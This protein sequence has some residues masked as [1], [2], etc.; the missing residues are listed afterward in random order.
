MLPVPVVQE[1]ILQRVTPLGVEKIHLYD[2]LGRVLAEAIVTPDPIPAW[3]NSA[4]DGYA[5]ALGDWQLTPEPVLTI[6]EELPAGKIPQKPLQPGFCSRV[7]TGALLPEGTEA[8]VMQEQAE[9]LGG[10]RVQL[11][12]YPRSGQFMR[13]RGEFRSSGETLITQG[14]AI[15]PAE[16][17]ILASLNKLQV[18]VYRQP[19]VA[20]LSTGDELVPLGVDP[21]SGQVLDS[22]QPTLMAL[23]R[24]C[25]GIPKAMGIVRD[26]PEALITLLGQCADADF[27]LSSG[28]VSVGTYDYVEAVLERL[29]A[30]VLVRQVNMK[31]GKPLTFAQWGQTLYWGLPGN[32]VSSFVGFWLMV[33]PALRKAAGHPH[34]WLPKEMT[35][36]TTAA[37]KSGGDRRHYLRGR[38][39]WQDGYHFEPFGLDNSGNFAN[40]SQVNAFAVLESGQTRVAAGC[41]VRVVVL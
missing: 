15:T 31:P 41:E 40:L 14:T 30:E 17:G 5:V 28:G 9:V 11:R 37:L 4:M 12:G 13:K 39:T 7:M 22:N 10:D 25:G 23:V 20:I 26:T 21:R 3:D 33:Y 19:L 18:P 8:V 36:V 1:L 27:I 32:P 2:S 24:Q 16:I 35:A 38:L 6:L 34:D 29:G